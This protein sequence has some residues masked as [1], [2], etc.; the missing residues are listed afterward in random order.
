MK[1]LVTDGQERAALAVVRT[2]GRAD[3]RTGLVSPF[4]RCLA[5]ASRHA[6]F[7][8]RA[9][10]PLEDPD[11]FCRTV[12]A[13]ATEREIDVVLPVSEAS[14]HAILPRRD[15]FEGVEIPF[16]DHRTFDAVCDKGRVC[17]IAQELGVTVPR[18]VSVTRKTG[19]PGVAEPLGFPVVVK[20]SRSVVR[21]EGRVVKT[22]VRHARDRQELADVLVDIPPSA[23]PVLV[24]ERIEGP[25]TGVFVL[26]WEGE[27][28]GAFC[29]RRIREKPPSGGVSVLRESVPLDREMLE[30]S[31]KLLERFGWRGVAMVEYKRDRKTGVPY[32]MEVNGRFWG[33]L[34]LAIDAGVDFPRLLVE[35]AAGARPEP[36]LEYEEGVRTRWFL[37]DVDHLL[38][39]LRHSP[40]DLGLG[41]DGPGR[42]SALWGFL[43]A[44]G[45][46]SRNEVF[47]PSDPGP[48]L[49]EAV[50]WMREV[51]RDFVDDGGAPGSRTHP[52]TGKGASDR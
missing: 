20:P 36:V 29:H 6:G 21:S 49:L 2:L 31:R 12:R 52:A 39:R 28:V 34:Q 23:Y 13:I 15:E 30:M 45:P 38:A 3:Y 5:G 8:R 4:E 41:S 26:L 48:G 24:Q 1:V 14:L 10:D 19:D 32:L 37:G 47:R 33:S 42:A 51:A 44:S 16:P 46:R 11:A 40:E 7:Q 50:E 43:A 22:S 18:Q 25:G 27:L 9:P 35:A 17:Q